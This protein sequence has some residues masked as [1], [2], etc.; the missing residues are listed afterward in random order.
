[1]DP[2]NVLNA[3]ILSQQRHRDRACET[4]HS[5]SVPM[6]NEGA[7]RLWQRIQKRLPHIQISVRVTMRQSVETRAY[8]THEANTRG[9]TTWTR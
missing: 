7:P 2:V 1:M 4:A 3:Q 9:A 8:P 5:E 6:T